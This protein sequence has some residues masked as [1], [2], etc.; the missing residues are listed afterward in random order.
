ML[1]C[2]GVSDGFVR[3][4]ALPAC[5][6]LAAACGSSAPAARTAASAGTSSV[7][8]DRARTSRFLA[9]EDEALGW[10]AAADPRLAGR[11][12]A[13]P[14]A[15][16]LGR[17]G[18]QAVLSEDTSAR[19]HGASLDLFAFRAR[20]WALTE[21]AKTLAA[22]T[23]TLP[24]AG[25]VGSGVSRP[26]LEREL[27]QRVI[28]EEQARAEDEARLGD[29][30]GDLVRGMVATWAP[31]SAPQEVPERDI[32][33]AKHLLEIGQ[34]LHDTAPRTGP[35]DLDLALQPLERL[36]APLEYPRG[37]AAIA[38]L[39][40]AIDADM[41][42]LPKIDVPARVARAA[43][44]HLGVDLD[45]AS[46]PSRL[47]G[48][49]TAL[50]SAA[51]KELDPL[52]DAGRQAAL[53]HA[54]ELLF[55]EAA[56][57][58]VTDSRVRNMAPPPERAAVCGV[59]RS[60]ADDSRAAGLVALHDDVLLGFAAVTSSPPS[61]TGLLSHPDIEQVDALERIA[62][63]RPVVA[64]GAA[65]AAEI[66]YTGDDPARR[67]AAW[68]ALGEAPLDVVARELRGTKP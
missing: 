61:R 3:R 15:D 24:D 2:P 66:L 51:E 64:L 18:T 20:A 46:M 49:E 33:A 60:M 7:E 56:C 39:W 10:M 8:D 68:R 23:G 6:L 54:R 34:S 26:K 27:V 63:E 17:I 22:D 53:G 25:P 5:L 62:R 50:K 45:V 48:L 67:L 36:L 65:L 47:R 31:P 55:V 44:V 43:K 13:P 35:P 29:S 9:E 12:N 11:V 32:W 16:I 52:D 37:T 42:A 14:N 21:A 58:P 57:P 4:A 59:L 41:R 40:I 1:G 19:I 30:A 38:Q 28:E